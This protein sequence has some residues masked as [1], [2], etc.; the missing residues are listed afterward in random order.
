MLRLQVRLRLAATW[1]TFEDSGLHAATGLALELRDLCLES[2]HLDLVAV[3]DMQ[4]GTLRGRGGDLAGA[5]EALRRAEQGRPVMAAA[6]QVKLLLNRGTLATQL[7]DSGGATKDLAQAARLAHQ[8]GLG[9]L[10]FLSVHNQ[11]YAEFIGG[12][13]PGALTLMERADLMDVE[14]DRG[15]ARLD[16]ARVLLEAGLIDEAHEV[17]VG[18]I[19]SYPASGSEHDLGEIELDLARCEVLM[20]Q[21]PAAVQRAVTARHRFHRRGEAGWR[22]AA[23]LVELEARATGRG[24]A[25]ARARL[26][27]VLGEAASLAGDEGMRQRAALVRAEALADLGQHAEASAAWQGART[28]LRSP[29]LATRLHARHVSAR[30]SAGTGR[31]AAAARTLRRAA[32]DLGA[33]G[34]QSAGLDLRTA[35]TVHGTDLVGLDLALAMRAGSAARVLARTELWRDVV[36]ALPPLRTSADPRRAEA[37]SRL[38][39]AREDLR[40]APPAA[41]VGRLRAEVTRAE[42]AV[43]ELD[44][45][46]DTVP[47]QVT[48][49]QGPLSAPAVRDAVRQAQ[50]SLLATFISDQALYAVLVRPDGAL[51]MHHLGSLAAVTG[52]VRSVQ[53]DLAA[54]ARLPSWSPLGPAVRASL[55]QGLTELDTTLLAPVAQAGLGARPLVVVPTPTLMP[56]PWGMLASRRGRATSVVRSATSW[57]RRHTTLSG[58]P[59]VRALAGPDVPLADTEVAAVVSAWGS[60][61]AVPATASRAADLVPALAECDLVHVAAHGEHHAQNPLFSSLRLGDGS[62]F[63]HEIEG[64]RLRATQV[65]LSACDGGRISVR[66]GEEPLG[67]TASLLALGV[68]T[69]IAAVSP[70]P[71]EVAHDVMTRYHGE[72][73]GG[74]DAATALA[75]AIAQGDPLAAS[76]TCFGSSW[77]C[78]SGSA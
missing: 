16:R 4:I 46:T 26:S 76:F 45:T 20:G 63:A 7:R 14:V 57:A 64:H 9:V 54:A 48:P 74:V 21:H 28:L 38:R 39:K 40:Q 72:I 37:L 3:C 12:D 18:A 43:R 11:G 8:V 34:R 67:M 71:D 62:V 13:L 30:I 33:A 77:R 55:E 60:G 44:W 6:D 78:E 65:V 47:A 68:P 61:Q 17:L 69:V 1:I 5:L 36:R 2:G 25:A 52:R 10:E 66:R 73:A 49:A 51:S 24:S 75:A 29:H 50:V 59:R 19:Q 70:V 56:L 53:A 32:D 22:R 31:A 42:K 58:D 27:R 35:L 15:I 41:P 23:Q